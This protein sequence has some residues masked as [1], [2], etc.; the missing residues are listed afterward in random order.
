GGGG[1]GG[2][3]GPQGG[4]PDLEAIL[5][6]GQDRLKN[7]MPGGSGGGMSAKGAV[8]IG[9]LAVFGWLATGF[10]T[11]RPDE[12]GIKTVFGKYMTKTAPG[13]DWNWPAPIGGVIKPRVTQINRMEIGSALLVNQRGQQVQRQGTEDSLMLTG[14]GNIVDVAF[15][16]QWQIDPARPENFVFNIQNPESNIRAVAE[17]S[18]REAIG[19]RPIQPILT[20]DRVPI[21]TEVRTL[22]QDTLNS[23]NAGVLIS[24][25]Q[26]LKADPPAQV[27]EAFRDVQ[28]AQQDQSRLRNE[29]ETYASRVVPEARGQAAR[30]VQEAEAYRERSVAEATGQAS[31][32]TQIYEQYKLAPDVTR[33]RLFLETMERVFGGMDKVIIDQN[34]GGAGNGV[35]PFL[36]LDQLQRRPTA[37]TPQQGTTR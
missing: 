17:S 19:R 30:L 14:D 29:A 34:T 15:Q 4:P 7:I 6:K 35:V 20:T 18:M 11:V 27:I 3:S 10:F 16:V 12:I 8:L 2:P 9:L 32:F 36:P 33:E 37:Q 25:L 13:L 22:L 26:M 24:G 1:G 28:A 21:E 23:Y 5:R 31:R